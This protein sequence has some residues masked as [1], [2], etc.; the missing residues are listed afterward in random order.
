MK[1]N[2]LQKSI[3][4]LCAEFLPHAAEVFVLFTSGSDKKEP[5]SQ[6]I[7]GRLCKNLLKASLLKKLNLMED[8]NL[9]QVILDL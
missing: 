1:S 5:F 2:T 8:L 6:D 4:G 9:T 3:L 7:Q